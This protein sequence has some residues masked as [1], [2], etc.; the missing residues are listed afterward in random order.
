MLDHVRHP[1]R[2]LV[3]SRRTGVQGVQGYLLGRPSTDRPTAIPY[4]TPWDSARR[5]HEPTR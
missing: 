4:L 1:P 5:N 3:T 2:V